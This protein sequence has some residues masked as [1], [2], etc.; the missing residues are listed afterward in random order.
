[1]SSTV[2]YVVGQWVRGAGFYGR[3]A[4]LA[5]LSRARGCVRVIGLRRVGK[6]SLLRQLELLAFG[7]DRLALFWDLQ[8]VDRASDLGAGFAEALLDAG[9]ALAAQG[10]A[11]EEVAGEDLAG[12]I[13]RLLE[14][15]AEG[16]RGLLLL[17]DEADELVRL[18]AQ[19]AAAVAAPLRAFATASNATLLLAGSP[20]ALGCGG[21]A[22][23]ALAGGAT[24]VSVYVGALTDDEACA[25]LRQD[26]LA[27]AY[28][29]TLAED[30]VRALAEAC[31]NHPLLLQLVGR[32]RLV[33]GSAQRALE[34][35]AADRTL[36]H[37]FAVDVELLSG[38]EREVLAAVAH[39]R[40]A[41]DRVSRADHPAA[42]RLLHLGCLAATA[43]GTLR[44]RSRFL[45]DWLRARG[46]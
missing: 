39:M 32:R 16:G 9:E 30:V 18:A 37:L 2:P 10:I 25:L 12:S 21:S 20:R 8:G 27:P 5:D 13:E 3:S 15:L 31:G 36:D 40:Q 17:C 26:Q 1:M 38:E 45:A 42:A 7:G 29:P 44:V 6:T 34:E 4:V 24:D 43:E 33:F 28:R 41:G 22:L 19:D 35:V 46:G 11:A 23:A 14:A